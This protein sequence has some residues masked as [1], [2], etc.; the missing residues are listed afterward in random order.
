M[1]APTGLSAT[2]IDGNWI[3]DW[4]YEDSEANPVAGFVIQ[5]LD[6]EVDGVPAWKNLAQT[7]S[8]VYRYRIGKLP[9]TYLYYRVAALNADGAHSAYSDDVLIEV[10][11]E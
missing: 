4:S 6:L 8:D 2:E 10:S 7:L 3:L 1:N 11:A 9:S 5:V